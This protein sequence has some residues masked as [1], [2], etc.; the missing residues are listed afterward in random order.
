[1]TLR[2][3]LADDHT[4]FRIGLKELMRFE[5]DVAVVAEA[6]SADEVIQAVEREPLDLAILDLNMPGNFGTALIGRVRRLQPSLAILVLSMRL[7]PAIITAALKSG[8]NGYLGKGADSA[9]LREA[10]QVVARQR[11]RYIDPAI[12]QSVL[13]A[14]PATGAAAEAP[15]HQLSR[16]EWQVL[17][18]ILK[19]LPHAEIANSLHLSVKTVSS[20]KVNLMQKIGVESLPDLVRYAMEHQITP[21]G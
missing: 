18:L 2:C 11:R 8:A 12:A 10:I 19:G 14:D 21:E 3:L 7:E 15:H 6:A 5:P 4:L 9:V 16:R 17:G 13:L 1:M 20:H